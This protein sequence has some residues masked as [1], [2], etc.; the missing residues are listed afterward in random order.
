[1]NRFH[2]S[3]F[4]AIEVGEDRIINMRRG[5]IGFPDARRFAIL[6]PNPNSALFWF[7]CLDDPE[8]AFVITDPRLFVPDFVI[9]FGPGVLRALEA[10]DPSRLEIYALV[11]I[12]PGQPAEMTANLIGPIVLNP[13]S[14]LAEQLVVE[15][16]PFSH[17]H[18]LLKK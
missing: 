7:Q 13:A 5:L 4:G 14:R 16:S 10:S 11:T 8:L 15:D 18:P 3:R 17:K 6:R 12:P 9:S 1:M 2:T